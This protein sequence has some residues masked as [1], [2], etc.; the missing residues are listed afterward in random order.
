MALFGSNTTL[1][2]VIGY[3]RTYD[4]LFPAVNKITKKIDTSYIDISNEFAS[5]MME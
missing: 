1:I 3:D 5:K 2:P 4:I